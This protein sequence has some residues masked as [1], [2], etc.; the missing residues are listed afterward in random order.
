MA[1]PPVVHAVAEF[2]ELTFAP[3]YG[4]GLENTP[5]RPWYLGQPS[6]TDKLL[7]PLYKMGIDAKLERELLREFRMRI[8]E[9]SDA[10]GVPDDRWPLIGHQNGLPT[11]ILEWSGN[12]LVAL[13]HAVES[14]AADKHGQVWIFNPWRFNELSA[15]I[16]YMPMVSSDFFKN[17]YVVKLDDPKADEVPSA[18]TPM[19][20][21]PYRNVRP[22]NTQDV[23]FTV[24]GYKQ[25]PL[26][27]IK[28]F[29]HKSKEYLRKVLVHGDSKKAI[30]KELHLLGITRANLFPGIPSLART[31]AY[32]YS[33]DFLYTDL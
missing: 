17:D 25:E 23:Y 28:F 4:V 19:A 1:D 26:E 13:F 11:R 22:Q 31:L 21:R 16:E 7:P 30:M 18:E 14:M 10:N 24:H 33:A 2:I 9:F 15:G 29:M 8:S 3:D 5:V 27:E 6:E 12:P 20:F 32:S